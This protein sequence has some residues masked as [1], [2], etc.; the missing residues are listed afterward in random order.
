MKQLLKTSAIVCW[1]TVR[2]TIQAKV[3]GV[4]KQKKEKTMSKKPN[5]V[6]YLSKL[7]VARNQPKKIKPKLPAETPEQKRARGHQNLMNIIV[8]ETMARHAELDEQEFLKR[9]GF[10]KSRLGE[11]QAVRVAMFNVLQG[12]LREY[13]LM[14]DKINTATK[15]LRTFAIGELGAEVE[16][17]K[18]GENQNG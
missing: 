13:V 10:D 6:H 4:I 17:K 11:E 5:N 8:G 15:T 2:I 3:F 7:D 14:H 1:G 9:I 12:L 16:E 18:E